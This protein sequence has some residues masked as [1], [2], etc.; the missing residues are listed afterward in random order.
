MNEFWDFFQS[1]PLEKPVLIFLVIFSCGIALFHTIIFTTLYNIKLKPKG[2][3]F[4]LNPAIV[5]GAF[6]IRSGYALL[7]LIIMFASLFILAIIGMIYTAFH[8]SE[9]EREFQKMYPKT[10]QPWY[11][12]LLGYGLFFL[13]CSLFSFGPIFI[14]LIIIAG[15]FLIGMMPNPKNRFKQYQATLPTSKIRSMAMGLVEVQG[16]IVAKTIMT[17][18]IDNIPCVGFKYV[19]ETISTDK[20]GH[21]SYSTI[22]DETKCNEFILQDE[23]GSVPV[24]PNKLDF[25]WVEMDGRYSNG[26][27][28]YTQYLLKPND[29][30]LII[31]KASVRENNEVIIEHENVK[32]VFGIAPASQVSVYN[33]YKPLLN[34]FVFFSAILALLVAVVL[35]SPINIHNG[36]VTI[37]LNATM[38]NWDT[39]LSKF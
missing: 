14:I 10:K 30:V 25:I 20:E 23:T 18:P 5:I 8:P 38:F 36:E 33:R 37:T 32:N 16:K 15:G 19:I 6:F 28:R 7:A 21:D 27:K 1:E 35:V 31:G 2:L 29:E 11:K 26:S 9:E 13:A 22:H 34:S 39:F 24:L 4:I 12:T 3:F 17:A